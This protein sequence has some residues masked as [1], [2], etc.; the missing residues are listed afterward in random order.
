[1][2][3][4]SLAHRGNPPV[5]KSVLWFAMLAAAS[6]IGPAALAGDS[7]SRPIEYGEVLQEDPIVE[8]LRR[9]VSK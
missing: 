2:T 7:R 6:V 1:M 8:I 3:S 9:P 5:F 4:A